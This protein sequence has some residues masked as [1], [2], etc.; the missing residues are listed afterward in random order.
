MD[1]VHL[2]AELHLRTLTSV[3]TEAN[4][5]WSVNVPGYQEDTGRWSEF[6]NEIN[7]N[8]VWKNLFYQRM[9]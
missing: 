9:E 1:R 5:R 3:N 2:L 4:N 7:I 6:R 8:N